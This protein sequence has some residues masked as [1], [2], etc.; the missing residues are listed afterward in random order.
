MFEPYDFTPFYLVNV[1]FLF[2]NKKLSA[3]D[4]LFRKVVAMENNFAVKGS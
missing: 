2:A 1:C 4:K 3:F